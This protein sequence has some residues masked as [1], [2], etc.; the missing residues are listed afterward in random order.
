M[1]DG[2][3]SENLGLYSLIRRG[4]KKIIVVDAEYDPN[5]VFDALNIVKD[6]IKKEDN[7][8]LE[9][10]NDDFKNYTPMD[11]NIHL[12]KGK[13]T[14]FSENSKNGQP[15]EIEIYYL[16]LSIDRQVIVD[17]CNNSDDYCTVMHQI[18]TQQ[19]FPHHSTIDIQYSKKQV[20]AYRDLGHLL[21]K[22]ITKNQLML[23]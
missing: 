18:N 15:Y 21:G 4:V 1:S 6:K 20:A 8:V 10:E 17:K 5:G 2:G 11:T 14:G 12:V 22:E 9:F 16:K 3:H 7:L 13:I 23:P 19:N